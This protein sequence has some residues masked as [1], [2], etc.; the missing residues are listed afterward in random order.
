MAYMGTLEA[1]KKWGYTPATISKWCREGLIEG[2]TQDKP[3]SPW[4]IPEN[5]K[6]PRRI[7]KQ[8]KEK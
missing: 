5:A 6:C 7:K 2:A 1:S 3:G 4:H 8:N